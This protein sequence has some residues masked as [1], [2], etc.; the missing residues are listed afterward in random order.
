MAT[1][2]GRSQRGDVAATTW[3]PPEGWGLALL[4]SA[5]IYG[6][7]LNYAGL[8]YQSSLFLSLAVCL[9]LLGV[10]ALPARR[11][12][13]NGMRGVLWPSVCFLVVVAAALLSLTPF[14]PGGPA[15]VWSYIG[16]SPGSVTINRTATIIEI[17]KLLGLAAIFAL[18]GI[19]GAGDARARTTLN[20]FVLA[21]GLFGLWAIITHA[22]GGNGHSTNRL[23]ANFLAPNTAGGFFGL[24]ATM[25]VGALVTA[26]RSSSKDRLSRLAPYAATLAVALIA[27]LMS[28]SRGGA[29]ATVI[30]FG[31]YLLFQIFAGKVRVGRAL[32]LAAIGGAV[33]LV[34]VIVGGE[35]M[36][37][38]ALEGGATA[39]VRAHMGEIHFKAFQ[40][41]PL[42][43][44]GLG[45]FDAINRSV[46]D[47]QNFDDL[48]AVR[49]THNV[50]IQW[51][52]EA[53]LIGALPMFACIGLIL[54][55]TYRRT[56]ARSR[57]TSFLFALLAADALVLFHGISDF[58]LQTY[59]FALN[60]SFL[61][62]LQYRL[63]LGSRA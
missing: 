45:T 47:A 2:T 62:G 34:A 26:Y 63:S 29:I 16:M 27:L 30:A 10:L 5:L 55:T 50:Y 38:R 21:G 33:A 52:E 13:L 28:G 56:L 17:I 25:A 51:L 24:V 46:M 3:R 4:C 35:V 48:W 40:A 14:G 54:I 19:M 12:E 58:D 22:S 41:A 15:P 20:T 39:D 8:T 31:A 32:I 36:I 1:T 11:A 9:V 42:M 53:G 7:H 6:A 60:W 23:E 61:L 44:Y 49:A 37:N 43:G 59:S 18:G 57:M